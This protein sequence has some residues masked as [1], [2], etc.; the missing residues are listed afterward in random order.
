[1]DLRPLCFLESRTVDYLAIWTILFP[2]SYSMTPDIIRLC[3]SHLTKEGPGCSGSLLFSSSFHPTS[4][5]LLYTHSGNSCNSVED[6]FVSHILRARAFS[7]KH[8]MRTEQALKLKGFIWRS[9]PENFLT[10]PQDLWVREK[11]CQG[12]YPSLAGIAQEE[13]CKPGSIQ[14]C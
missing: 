14:M 13:V 8:K 9:G 11:K 5:T 1:M 12:F 6:V 2:F 7:G 10:S 3:L 4:W